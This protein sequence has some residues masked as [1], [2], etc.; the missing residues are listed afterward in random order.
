MDDQNAQGLYLIWPDQGARNLLDESFG[1]SFALVAYDNE[2]DDGGHA[3]FFGYQ[4]TTVVTKHGHPMTTV[5]AQS[6]NSGR[7]RILSHRS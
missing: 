3:I 6:A 7:G 1:L 2:Q 4:L 5:P